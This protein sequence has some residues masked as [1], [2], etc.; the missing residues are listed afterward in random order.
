MSLSRAKNAR[1]SEDL[2]KF[3]EKK[4]SLTVLKPGDAVNFPKL[5]DS[6]AVYGNRYLLEDLNSVIC[7]AEITL[8]I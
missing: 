8:D 7:W 2:F 4:Y 3:I 5:G 6:I 1:E